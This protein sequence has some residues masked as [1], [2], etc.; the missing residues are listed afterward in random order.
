MQVSDRTFGTM[1]SG[2]AKQAAATMRGEHENRKPLTLQQIKQEIRSLERKELIVKKRDALGN[3]M[4]R[5]GKDG[6]PDVV[7]VAKEFHKPL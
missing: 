1:D 2:M 6:K 7:W 3:V 5:P 4:T